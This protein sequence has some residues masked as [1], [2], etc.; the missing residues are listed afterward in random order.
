MLIAFMLAVGPDFFGFV[1]FRI[2]NPFSFVIV[3][4]SQRTISHVLR[5]SWAI[6]NPNP[7][8]VTTNNAVQSI[9]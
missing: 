2:F 9:T 3:K 6:S 4:H 1:V 8:S 5:T 7:S